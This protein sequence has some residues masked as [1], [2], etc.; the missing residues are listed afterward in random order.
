MRFAVEQ[1]FQGVTSAHVAAAYREQSLYDV[2]TDLPFVGRPEPVAFNRVGD[3]VRLDLRYR[4]Q[5]ELPGAARAFIDPDKLT[6]VERSTIT[7]DGATTFRVLPDNYAELLTCGGRAALTEGPAGVVRQTTGQLDLDLGWQGAL[8]EGQVA[9]AIV[10]GFRQSIA[11]QT[12]QVR[13]FI[14]DRY[15]A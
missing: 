6:F 13:A 12:T 4:V 15:G 7:P 1:E 11:A 2:I 5:L 8:F 9:Q 10:N 14:S 3:D